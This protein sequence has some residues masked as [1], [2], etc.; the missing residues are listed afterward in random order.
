MATTEDLEI[1]YDDM[2]GHIFHWS[3]GDMEGAEGVRLAF[4]GLGTMFEDMYESPV[5][6]IYNSTAFEIGGRYGGLREDMFEFGLAF[7]VKPTDNL[8]WRVA[9]S[10]FR[11]AL[12]YTRDGRIYCKIV[13]QS[14]RYLTVRMQKTPKLKVSTS[15][16]GTDPNKQRYGLLMVYFVGA[17]PRWCEDDRVSTYTATTDTTGLATPVAVTPTTATT[18]GTLA[19][20]TYYYKVTALNATGETPG[21]NQVSKV[22]TGSTSTTTTT[23]GAITGATGYKIYRSTSSGAEHYLATVGAVTTY[24]DT[25]ASTT[26]VVCPTVDTTRGPEIGSLIVSNP[27]NCEQWLKFVAQAGNAGIVWT[28]PD[29]SWGDTRFDTVATKHSV[30]DATRMIIMPPLILSEHIVVDTDEMTIAGQVVSDLDTEVYLRMNGVEFL[31]PIPP[32]TQPTTMPISVTGAQ[33]GNLVEVRCPLSWSR[34]WG[35]ED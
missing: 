21:S 2:N 13:G 10:R 9:E 35:L 7:N 18:G 12:S 14:T 22:T 8:P 19:A 20:A 15:G 30:L 1:W 27:T 23:W 26:G 24:T 34:P 28:L 25:G 5:E 32:Y 3:G 11:K 6:A 16:T 33:A 17:Y 29:Y 4:A 31:Y